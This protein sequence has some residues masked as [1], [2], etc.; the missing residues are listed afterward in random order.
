MSKWQC[1]KRLCLFINKN[2]S[3]MEANEQSPTTAGNRFPYEL[4]NEMIKRHLASINQGGDANQG[5]DV[6]QS[7][8]A[9]QSD[10]VNR[11]TGGSEL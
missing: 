11:N 7:G 10:D 4:V 2:L 8:D 6:N 1:D 9:N 3:A 5:G